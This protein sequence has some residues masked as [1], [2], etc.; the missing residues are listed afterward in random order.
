MLRVFSQ[1]AAAL[2]FTTALG[3]APADSAPNKLQGTPGQANQTKHAI[4]ARKLQVGKAS[5]YG[6]LFQHKQTASGEPFDMY[7]FTAAHRTLP[8]GSWVKVTDLKN[9]RSVIV[10]INDRGPVPKNRIIDLSYGAAKMLGMTENG[11]HPVRVELIDTLTISQSDGE[12][13]RVLMQ[14]GRP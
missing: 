3:A 7:Q 11:I 6:R 5:W 1:I 9:D 8:L 12:S 14:D 13:N 4:K 10:R 2:V